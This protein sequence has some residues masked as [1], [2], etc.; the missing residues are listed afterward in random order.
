[1]NMHLP[2]NEY[3][4]NLNI[5]SENLK[6]TSFLSITP[7]AKSIPGLIYDLCGGDVASGEICGGKKRNKAEKTTK[8]KYFKHDEDYE[9]KNSLL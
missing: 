3:A 7:G 4:L 5:S 2:Q 6:R 1:M 9:K 8:K